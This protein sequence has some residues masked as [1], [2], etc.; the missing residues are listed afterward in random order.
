[1]SREVHVRFCEGL[2]VRFPRA[3]RL[4]I[5]VKSDAAAHRVYASVERFLT[6]TLKLHVNHDKRS[7]CKTQVLEYVGYEFRGY[8][9]PFRVSRKKLDAF[10][11]SVSEIFRRNRGISMKK[12]FAEFRS[13]AIGWLGYFQLDQVKT[14]FSTLDK[15]LRRRVRACYS[16]QWRKPKTRRRNLMSFGLSY[17]DARPFAFSG[18]GAWR[19]AKTSGVQRAL[20]NEYLNSEGLPESSRALATACILATNRPR[21]GPA[22]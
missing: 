11:R 21:S 7:V 3:T 19:L 20:S 4:V 14:T 16:K 8:G 15:W 6:L 17:R 1:M 5:F 9:G 18:K 22:C 10:K 12:R 13:Y 2:G